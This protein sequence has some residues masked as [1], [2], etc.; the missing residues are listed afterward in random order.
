[1]GGVALIELI[2]YWSKGF[3]YSVLALLRDLYPAPSYF[4]TFPVY[5]LN[6]Q[7]CS[8]RCILPIY[9]SATDKPTERSPKPPLYA[10]SLF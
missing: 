7:S 9:H 2:Q 1:M 10:A 5:C 6:K 4:P 8:Q 3:V